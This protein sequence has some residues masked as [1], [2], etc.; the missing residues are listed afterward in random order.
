MQR[1]WAGT[2]NE[3]RFDVSESPRQIEIQFR[4]DVARP[5]DGLTSLPVRRAF[6]QA[7]DRQ[8]AGRPVRLWIGAPGR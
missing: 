3:V 5:R 4:P 2:G 1:R 8:D 7:I 6:Y